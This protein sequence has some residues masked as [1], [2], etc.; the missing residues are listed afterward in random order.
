MKRIAFLL[1]LLASA[2]AANAEDFKLPEKTELPIEPMALGRGADPAEESAKQLLFRT[3]DEMTGPCAAP[4][5]FRFN[6]LYAK[7]VMVPGGTELKPITTDILKE[8][9]KRIRERVQSGDITLSVSPAAEGSASWSATVYQGK[10]GGSLEIKQDDVR[11]AIGEDRKPRRLSLLRRQEQL[12]DSLLHETSH[13]LYSILKHEFK[14]RPS[15]A[16]KAL[17]RQFVRG[18]SWWDGSSACD[19]SDEVDPSSCRTMLNEFLLTG[20]SYNEAVW[21]NEETAR[22]VANGV[23]LGGE[24]CARGGVVGRILG[25][26]K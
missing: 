8:V 6:T 14:A 18:R 17:T 19:H 3:L 11:L 22:Q 24:S 26:K 1:P 5:I 2:V 25:L 12:A 20:G 10:V 9:A 16:P 15:W 21:P 23:Y 7:G 4:V 13:A